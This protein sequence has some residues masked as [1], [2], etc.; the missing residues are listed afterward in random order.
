[1][2]AYDSNVVHWVGCAIH[3]GGE[4]QI[5]PF[6]C[7][8][9]GNFLNE[10]P[11]AISFH[12][13]VAFIHRFR[14]DI[15]NSRVGP[16]V[17]HISKKTCCGPIYPKRGKSGHFQLHLYIPLE[18]HDITQIFLPRCQELSWGLIWLLNSQIRLISLTEKRE[19]FLGPKCP[20]MS[21]FTA[22]KNLLTNKLKEFPGGPIC[23]TF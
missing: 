13:K 23:P 21:H 20:E 14:A 8:C 22:M 3:L 7:F 18:A 5:G 16:I 15:V 17:A 11:K 19:L 4:G 10:S 6:Y 2:N 12:D 9:F 1:M